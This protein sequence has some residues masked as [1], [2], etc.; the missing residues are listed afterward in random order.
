[1]N[2][3]Q[4]RVWAFGDDLDTDLIAPGRYLM[5]DLPEIAAHVM[6]GIRP[7][8]A[9]LVGQG[10]I[11]V[12]G[13]NFGSG[14]SRE[15]AARALREAGIVAVVAKSFSRI[16]FRNSIN[17]GLVPVECAEANVIEEGQ[18]VRIDID[19]GE[20]M[21]IDTGRRLASRP[22]PPEVAAIMEA[23]G[24]VEFLRTRVGGAKS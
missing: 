3:F 9:D 4:G 13:T 6:E 21:I 22:L 2:A 19:I 1:M 16:F 8:F 14:S 24:L 23:G 18:T 20:V 11:I 12:A 7:G 10:D 5:Y 17:V 15:M